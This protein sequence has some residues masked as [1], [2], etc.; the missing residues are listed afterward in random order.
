MPMQAP[1][2]ASAEQPPAGAGGN[3]QIKMQLVQLV[4]QAMMLA[5]KNGIDFKQI[6]M[7]VM[8]GG[9]GGATPPPMP[10]R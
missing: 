9:G 10:P 2:S 4:K 1:S 7:E 6:L 8:G 3:P 5:Q